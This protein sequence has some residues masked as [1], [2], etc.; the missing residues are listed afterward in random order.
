MSNPTYTN[1]FAT[2]LQFTNHLDPSLPLLFTNQLLLT[3]P[4]ISK[5][6]Y[7]IVCKSS[8]FQYKYCDMHFSQLSSNDFFFFFFFL[9]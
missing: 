2:S 8:I 1:Y 4:T 7:K 5:K 9:P 6:Y 3:T